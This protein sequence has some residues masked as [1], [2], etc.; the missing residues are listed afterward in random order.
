[1]TM[2][3]IYT[4]KEAAKILGFSTNTLYKYL[5]EGRIQAARGQDQGRYRIP[6]QSIEEFLGHPLIEVDNTTIT[7]PPKPSITF[8]L[9]ISRILITISL[10]FIIYD[11]VTNTSFSL[12]HQLIR[13]TTVAIFFI[14]AYQFGGFQKSEINN[15]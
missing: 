2:N 12:Y 13:V 5:D 6:Q 3:K 9:K 7:L 4:V 15:T 14:L 11:A 10:I 8:P 1:M